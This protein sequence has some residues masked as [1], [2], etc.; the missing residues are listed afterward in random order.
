MWPG[1][2]ASGKRLSLEVTLEHLQGTR[3]RLKQRVP[4]AARGSSELGRGSGMR[5]LPGR[6]SLES[7]SLPGSAWAERGARPGALPALV[8]GG[9]AKPLHATEAE[10]GRLRGG[11]REARA[12]GAGEAR[13][14]R[15]RPREDMM[16]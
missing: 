7:P 2:P 14:S 12:F 11:G 10:R 16:L 4:S 5:R 13:R 1:V 6:A 9:C 3:A 8:P 15:G